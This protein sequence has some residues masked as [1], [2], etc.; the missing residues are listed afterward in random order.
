MRPHGFTLVEL[1]VVLALIGTILTI[2]ALNFSQMSRKS[3]IEKQINEMYLEIVNV[4][5]QAVQNRSRFIITFNANSMAINRYNSDLDGDGTTPV[6]TKNLIFPIE[7]SGW[8]SPSTKD[9][10]INTQG[11]MVDPIQKAVCI[12]SDVSPNVDSLVIVQSQ[13][14]LGQLKDQGKDCGVSN[15]DRK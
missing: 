10:V 4:Q 11:I 6:L 9:I 5:R 14:S 1:V 2:A 3:Q 8:N 12:K 13:I 7:I 15:V